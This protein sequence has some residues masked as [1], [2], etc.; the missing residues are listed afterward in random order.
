MLRN[1]TFQAAL[2]MVGSVFCFSAVAI[3]S[4]ELAAEL[5]TYET[6]FY[7]SLVGWPLIFGTVL[8]TGNLARLKTRRLPMHVLRNVIHF[9][10]QN[11]WIYAVSVAP[12]AQVFALEFTMP[13]WAVMLSL[14]F[15]GEKLT[16]M[17]AMVTAAGLVGILII[18]RP[19]TMGIGPGVIEAASAAFSFALVAVITRS[20]ARTD[21]SMTVVFWLITLQVLLGL[22]SAGWDGDIARPSAAL[23][24]WILVVGVTGLLAHSCLTKALSLA[25]AAVITPIDFS[26]LPLISVVALVLYA[27][28]IEPEVWIGAG[29]IFFANYLNLLHETR[30]SRVAAVADQAP[31]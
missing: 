13:V 8:A 29:I 31:L 21:T 22:I 7:R 30:K 27:E 28:P 3:A 23:I 2:W 26:R 19:W 25:P 17:R 10:G 24:P 11:L 20:L 18:T 6:M 9:G 15:L 4:R 14:L 5:D 12:L 16:R 1:P